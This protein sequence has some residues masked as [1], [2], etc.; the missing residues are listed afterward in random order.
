MSAGGLKGFIKAALLFQ[1]FAEGVLDFGAEHRV[2]Q[3][4]AEGADEAD[5]LTAAERNLTVALRLGGPEGRALALLALAF[6]GR[7]FV[8]VRRQ[9]CQRP[10]DGGGL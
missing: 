6:I 9:P 10:I 2:K 3:V 5:Y 8:L 7:A 1:Q 4:L